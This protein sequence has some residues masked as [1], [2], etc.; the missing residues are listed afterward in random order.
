MAQDTSGT[1][2]ATNAVAT[3]RTITFRFQVDWAGDGFS[4]T[5]TWTDESAY[6]TRMRG[7]MQAT[8]YLHSIATI[9]KA[10]ANVVYVTCRNPEVTSGG[11][12]LRFSP[13][14]ANGPL[15]TYIGGGKIF[16]TRARVRMGFS[17]EHLT[18]ITGYIVDIE[19]DYTNRLVTFEIRDRS[20]ALSLAE[21]S[22]TL[23]E[24]SDPKTYIEALCDLDEVT[25]RD[26][27]AT[28]ARQFDQ[29]MIVTPYMWMDSESVWEE[30]SIVAEAQLGRIWFDKDGN[31]HFDDGGH[32]VRP[33]SD[34][35]DDPRTSQ[36]SL[37]VASFR[38]C[39]PRLEVDNVYNAITVEYA[40]FY[41][42]QSQTIYAE[43]QT[44]AVKSGT[45]L[46]HSTAYQYPA[47]TLP[48]L[49]TTAAG[50]LVA[51]SSGGRDIAS[52]LTITGTR[53]ATNAEFSITNT[54]PFGTDDYTVYIT[55]FELVGQPL[56]S[57]NIAEYTVE[58]SDSIDQFGYKS[59]TVRNE[60]I[61]H[62]RHAQMVGDYM[63][64]RYKMP[65]THLV[66][67][68]IPARPWLEVGDRI[69]VTESLTGI[70]LDCMI[71]RMEWTFSREN[72]LYTQ[73]LHVMPYNDIFPYS[74]YFILGESVFGNG[75]GRGRLFW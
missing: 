38:D 74:N 17:N 60:Y 56:L 51:V 9:G 40:P 15:Y 12:G 29:G 65:V 34:A 30:M 70:N 1:S 37:T 47:A 53:T 36:V 28:A 55:K 43:S 73:T 72:P 49:P 46:T 57:G 11:S 68:G 21:A 10:A 35:W 6:V 25:S 54:P 66:I 24:N 20:A 3:S 27:I 16:M 44:L 26:S 18:Q 75:E 39:S 64:S 22:T 45:T 5:G 41:A 61:Q 4:S 48:A 32:W 69:T 52:R 62:Y 19:E 63:L 33:D 2:I 58:D 14:N 8:D 59:W 13:T 7:D 42:G 50:T 71:G 67:R 31:L 23:Y